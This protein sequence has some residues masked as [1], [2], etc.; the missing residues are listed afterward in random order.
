[1]LQ[2]VI[3]RGSHCCVALRLSQA[4][5]AQR[6]GLEHLMRIVKKDQHDL[7]VGKSHMKSLDVAGSETSG[8]LVHSNL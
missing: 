5:E 6:D 4:L 8:T 1:M 2:A 3:S 7:E